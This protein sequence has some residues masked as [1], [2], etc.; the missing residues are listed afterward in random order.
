MS[1]KSEMPTA[2]RIF[3]PDATR[4]ADHEQNTDPTTADQ[5]MVTPKVLIFKI[6]LTSF[7]LLNL[8]SKNVTSCRRDVQEKYA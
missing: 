7:M 4:P 2:R 1:F 3:R 8:Y 5:L 6:Q